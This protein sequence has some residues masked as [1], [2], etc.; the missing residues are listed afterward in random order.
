[1]NLKEINVAPG[2]R[3][4][5]FYQKPPVYLDFKIYLFNVTNKDEV[6][7]GSE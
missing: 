2:T 7:Q 1:M 3:L 6:N 4:R 5:G